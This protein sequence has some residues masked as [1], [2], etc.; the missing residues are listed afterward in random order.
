MPGSTPTAVPTVTPRADQNR[1]IGV[2]ATAK[3]LASA[4][5]VSMGL[6]SLSIGPG[7]LRRG[8]AFPSRPGCARFL[9]GGFRLGRRDQV[10]DHAAG[11]VEAEAVG[12]DDERRRGEGD[13]EG[14]AFLTPEVSPSRAQ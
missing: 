6:L 3:P 14:R 9:F 1:L 2:N 8:Q 4:A 7:A 5:R 13:A 10:G 11:Q 12:E